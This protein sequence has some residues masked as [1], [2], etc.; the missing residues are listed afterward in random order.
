MKVPLSWLKEYVSFEDEKEVARLLTSIGY[1]QDGPIK[2][3]A[4]DR[5]LDL[6]VRQNRS[7]GLSLIGVAREVAAVLNTD[8]KL[9]STATIVANIPSQQKITIADDTLCYRFQAIVLNDI[10]V[11]A[12]PS[13]LQQCLVAYGIQPINNVVDITNYVMVEFGQPLHAFDADL[14]P[15]LDLT[16]R[17]ARPDEELAVLS[18]ENVVLVSD[19][20]I[21]ASGENPVAL[22][23]VKGGK[24]SSVVNTTTQIVLE[25]ATYNQASV[26]R[27]SIR[28]ALRTEASTRLEKFLHP[29][30]TQVA[31]ERAVQ[32]LQDLTHAKIISHTDI[33]PNPQPAITITMRL[34]RL[35]RVAGV[36]LSLVKAAELLEKLQVSVIAQTE[37]DLTV[38]V[39]YFRTDLDQEDDI[40]EEVVRLNGYDKIPEH[41]P[42]QASPKNIQSSA[43][44][45]EETVRDLLASMGFDEQITEPLTLEHQPVLEPVALQNSLTSEKTMLRTTLSQSLLK[46]VVNRK[47]FHHTSINVFEV[48]K[49]YFLA[50]GTPQEKRVVGLVS[51]GGMASFESVKGV[52]ELLLVR[53]GYAYD[54]QFVEIKMLAVDSVF[55]QIDLDA[56]LLQ[57]SNDVIEKVLI[58][59]PQVLYQD[60]S[61]TVALDAQVGPI[62]AA[63]QAAH[64]LISRVRLGEAPF[65]KNGRKSLFVKVTFG[66]DVQVLSSAEVEPQRLA[67]VALLTDTFSAHFN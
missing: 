55:A 18:G 3:S 6:E 26:R 41:L 4:G 12:S 42:Q 2:D 10:Q 19:D 21:I 60:F 36:S 66:N 23:G 58:Y 8:L 43:Y 65:V 49:I 46:A 62:L 20:I 56:L 24:A 52:V 17:A 38:R 54:P 11:Q 51:S 40:I 28:H 48:G 39:P 35:N 37:Q 13:W 25:A 9:P 33:Y 30:L 57:K 27:S 53:L 64:P 44:A 16:I 63:I 29:D 5:V 34:A 14:L 47:K 15:S 22:A 45:L 7:D 59:P 32:L 1:M 31:L 50:A 61:F 67:I